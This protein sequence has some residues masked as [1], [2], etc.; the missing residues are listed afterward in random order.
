[1]RTASKSGWWLGAVLLLASQ[2]GGA[3]QL[4]DFTE[5]VRRNS[6]SVV[7]VSTSQPGAGGLQ[8]LLPDIPRDSPFY[9]FFRRFYDQ[10]PAPE[11]MQSLGSGFVISPD[12]YI[13]TNAHVVAGGQDIIVRLSDRTEKKAELIGMDERFDIALIKIDAADLPPA[14]IG[15]S[16]SLAVGQWV[17]AI[18][19]PFGLEHTATQ[20]IISALGRELPG[21]VYVPFIQTDVAV[22]PGSSGG[23]LFNL[24]GEVIG[25]NAQIFTTS[26]GYIGLS[27]AIPINVAMDAVKQIREKGYVTH[28]WLGVVIQ[29][30]S[31]AVAESFGLK[32]PRGALVSRVMPDSPAARAGLRSGDIIVQYGD[33]PIESASALPPAVTKTPVGEQVPLTVIREGKERRINVT[34]GELP[35]EEDRAPGAPAVSESRLNITVE[36]LSPEQRARFGVDRGVLVRE[37]RHGP[38]AEAGLRAGDVLLSLGQRDIN[39]PAE[40]VETVRKLPR[41]RPAPMLIW[42][43]GETQFLPLRL[44]GR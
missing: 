4:P 30:M 15:D 27:F 31:P 14:R 2:A 24:D 1:M 40:L 33:Q 28:G 44:P 6:E 43:D 11:Q 13:V 25:V 17:L 37:V 9:E 16:D 23:P 19:S 32:E 7:N 36:A 42:R 12:G 5:L 21:D 26:G 10:L 41:D 29:S 22:N 8:Q 18:G 38:A 39:S 34:I 3:Q 35:K 20:G